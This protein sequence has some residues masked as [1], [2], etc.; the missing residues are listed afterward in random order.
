MPTPA[1]H[2]SADVI[3]S[4]IASRLLLLSLIL[5]W[6]SL[7][8]PYDT[9]AGLDPRCLSDPSPSRSP[10]VQPLLPRIGSAI[11]RSIVWDGVYYVRISQCGY[12]YE[13]T[14]AFFPLLPICISLLSRTVLSPLVSV[15]GY[16]AVLGLSGY[17][18]SNMAF[19]LATLY[20]YR[21]SL[22]ILKDPEAS[23][24][25]SMLF[26]FNP[27]SIFYSSIYSES[28]Y[29]L[30]SVGGV[31]HLLSGFSNVAVVWLTLS[32]FSRSNGMLN[33][34]Y[35]LFQ[36]MH[37]ANEALFLR[38]KI[39]LAMQVLAVAVLRA[40]CIFVPFMA[41]QIFG[42]YNL[43][44]GQPADEKRPWC[45]RNLAIMYNYV[46]SKY[47]GVGFLAYFQIKQLPNFLLASP[48]LSL[49]LSSIISYARSRPRQ[50]LS[51]GFL[52]E[53]T[54]VS[55][56]SVDEIQEHTVPKN[57]ENQDIRH[58]KQ[59]GKGVD[60]YMVKNVPEKKH[61]L[62][63][64]VLPFILHLGFMAAT[65]FFVMHVQV[66]TRFLSAS[67]PLYWFASYMII[68]TS[69]SS[70]QWGYTIWAYS[71]AYILLGS[72]LFSNFYPFT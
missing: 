62:S 50:F 59:I 68:S 11:E 31:F 22:I 70:G 19:V 3:R 35:V 51:L 60:P 61:Y 45:N 4:A 21:L 69:G 48:I 17:L 39:W 52:N 63:P 43:C 36:A 29:A 66:A 58:R 1:S 9:S 15:I 54:E 25:A 72:L 71:A 7:A 10:R 16:R 34:G 64:L 65:A 42:Y 32:G 49:A 26:C 47:W 24:R 46:Q 55:Y 37:R 57:C 67:A 38:K 27:A 56:S 14:Y 30:F 41:F 53:T 8:S 18:I 13:Q 33:A 5:L 12:E 44:H 23:F 40:I 28:L 6:R 2:H 20:F